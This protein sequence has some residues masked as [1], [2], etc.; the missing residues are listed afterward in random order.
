MFTKVTFNI[1]KLHDGVRRFN[2]QSDGLA[3]LFTL[4]SNLLLHIFISRLDTSVNDDCE[5]YVEKEKV[6]RMKKKKIAVKEGVEK[7]LAIVTKHFK[8]WP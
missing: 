1:Q 2:L 6:K 3:T 8:R 7:N 5:D 4:S